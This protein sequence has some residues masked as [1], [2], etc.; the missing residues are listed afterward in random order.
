MHLRNVLLTFI[1][2]V[3]T[4]PRIHSLKAI[5]CDSSNVRVVELLDTNIASYCD[6][7]RTVEAPKQAR[8]ELWTK[9]R[10]LF[11]ISMASSEETRHEVF[12]WSMNRILLSTIRPQTADT[13]Y[14]FYDAIDD[15]VITQLKKWNI[16]D[17]VAVSGPSFMNSEKTFFAYNVVIRKMY[18]NVTSHRGVGITGH[19]TSLTN[20]CPF[21]F[22]LSMGRKWITEILETTK[23]KFD[24]VPVSMIPQSY[25]LWRE[26]CLPI[27]C[28]Q[29]AQQ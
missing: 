18:S 7:H 24:R 23:K 13:V 9:L 25:S 29:K 14:V 6:H 27:R 5:I 1:R 12:A 3:L 22:S 8:Y 16:E 20:T 26:F 19:S 2:L 11:Q 4:V 10:T 15:D 17:P 21:F 28:L